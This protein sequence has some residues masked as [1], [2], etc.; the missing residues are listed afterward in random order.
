[1]SA[2]QQQDQYSGQMDG[3]NSMTLDEPVWHT[4]V[5]LGVAA[6]AALCGGREGR[7]R[8]SGFA[9]VLACCRRSGV[10]NVAERLRKKE[11][12]REGGGG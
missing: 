6:A 8:M 12:G 11:G 7:A 10:L 4:V 1:M 3:Q 9:L 5:R 2:G